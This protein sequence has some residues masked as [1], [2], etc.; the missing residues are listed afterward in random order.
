MRRVIGHCRCGVCL[1]RASLWGF[2]RFVYLF[3]YHILPLSPA[4]LFVHHS[5]SLFSIL[6]VCLASWL[7]VHVCGSDSFYI[8]LCVCLS[9]HLSVCSVYLLIRLP[10]FLLD[11]LSIYLSISLYI[12]FTVFFS[13]YSC[14]L[15]PLIL[16]SLC[17]S[18]S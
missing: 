8:C 16:F 11:S 17:F 18:H 15:S 14:Y 3:L 9:N 12:W 10:A 1:R 7:F 5:T 13:L 6:Y 4:L 2:V